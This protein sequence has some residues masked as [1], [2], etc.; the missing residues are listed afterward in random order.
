MP[1]FKLSA[2]ALC[3]TALVALP[4]RGQQVPAPQGAASA[5]SPLALETVTVTAQKRK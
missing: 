4:A 2:V 5:P 1:H 3:V